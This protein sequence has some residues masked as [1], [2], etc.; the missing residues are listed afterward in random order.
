MNFQVIGTHNPQDFYNGVEPNDLVRVFITDE[1]GLIKVI[2]EL[3]ND[4]YQV[5]TSN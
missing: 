2:K 3:L 4:G 1:E 5:I